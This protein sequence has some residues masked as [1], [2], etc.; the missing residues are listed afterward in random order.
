MVL[1][2]VLF[3]N[4]FVTVKSVERLT[5]LTN[6]GARNLVRSAVERGW[7]TELGTIGRG[8]RSYWVAQEVFDVIEA[9]MVYHLEDDAGTAFNQRTQRG[10]GLPA[11]PS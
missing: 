3:T 10:W 2:R 4:P 11:S 5:G 6:Q 9:P 7:L 1:A 8:G